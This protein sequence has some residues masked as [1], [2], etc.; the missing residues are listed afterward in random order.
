MNKDLLHLAIENLGKNLSV[1]IKYEIEYEFLQKDNYQI[2]GKLVFLNEIPFKEFHIEMKNNLSLSVLSNLIKL[3]EKITNLLV[4]SDYISKP[5]KE[6]LRHKNIS[7]LDAAG[8]FYLKKE[9][10]FIYIETNKTNRN[11][12]KKTN[13]AFSPAGL[14]VIYNLLTVPN[15]LTKSYRDIAEQST[16]SIH[17]V[18]KVIKE[19]LRDSYIIKESEKNY[20]IKDKERLFQDWVTLFNKVL[21]PKLKQKSYESLKNKQEL[22]DSVKQNGKMDSIGGELA[23]QILTDYL[24]A[25]NIYLYTE[26][27]FLE[28]SKEHRLIPS[29]NGNVMLIEKFWKSEKSSKYLTVHPIL[30]YADLLDNPTPRNI[31]TAQLLF[32]KHI[33]DYVKTTL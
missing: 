8:N 21:R 32:Q 1:D 7:Y 33:K 3:N 10:L 4:V 9:N 25:E 6:K 2:D 24:I 5:L 27:T 22:F 19:L 31:E 23:A 30:V 29:E 13:K 14:K 18:G 20:I 26:D 11:N 16:V 17:T 28:L 15:L 12:F